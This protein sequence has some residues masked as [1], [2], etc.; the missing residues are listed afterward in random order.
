MIGTDNAME[1]LAGYFWAHRRDVDKF[2]SPLRSLR[3]PLAPHKLTLILSAH[4][5]LNALVRKTLR[6]QQSPRSFVSK[7]LHFHCPA[8][9][10][11]DSRAKSSLV[12][13]CPWK[14][15]LKVVEVPQGA[16]EEYT[17][18][19][20]R[21]WHLYQRMRKKKVKVSARLLDAFL[22]HYRK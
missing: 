7:Y 13:L 4:G 14:D 22:L 15:K 3:E 9:P 12:K 5:E 1:K 21:F 19:V 18:F 20:L 6:N 16:D 17:R 10:I 11:Y 2:L 8:V